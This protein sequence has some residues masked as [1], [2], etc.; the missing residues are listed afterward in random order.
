MTGRA[1]SLARH[2]AVAYAALVVYA[3]L[4]PLSGWRE[5]VGPPFAWLTAP[6]PRYYTAFDLATN[7]AAYVPLG[8]LAVAAAGRRFPPWLAALLAWLGASLLSAGMEMLQNFLP[9]RVPSNVDLGC[10]ALGAAAGCALGLRYGGALA[11]GGALARWRERRFL[12]G[13]AGDLGLVL[14]GAWLL[15]QL[16]PRGPLFGNGDLRGALGLVAPIGYGGALFFALDAL[17]AA[18]GAMGAGLIVRLSLREPSVATIAG[19]FALALAAKALAWAMLLE[20]SAWLEWLTPGA[21]LGLLAGAAGLALAVWLPRGVQRP[22]AAVALLAMTALTNLAPEYPYAA[23]AAPGH[24]LNFDGLTR[25][26]SSLWP[27]LAL[28]WLLALPARRERRR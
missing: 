5:A 6:W 16:D 22:L 26:A 15:T 28:A 18:A 4:Y 20:P 25:I 7:V 14:I 2:L 21:R 10:N 3:S 17:I 24:F 27:F 9:G 13:R 23:P 12:R 1:H 8:L 11:G 19:A